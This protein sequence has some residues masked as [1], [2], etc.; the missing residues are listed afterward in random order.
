MSRYWRVR[1]R[2]PAKGQLECQGDRARPADRCARRG[3]LAP[4]SCLRS[5]AAAAWPRIVD[6]SDSGG[7]M[8]RMFILGRC[9][10]NGREQTEVGNGMQPRGVPNFPRS[11][12]SRFQSISS[13]L[14]HRRVRARR[15]VLSQEQPKTDGLPDHGGV[16]LEREPTWNSATRVQ[17]RK[18][19][20]AVR[21]TV[22]E[23]PERASR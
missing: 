14:R 8:S 6:W 3:P 5:Q 18:R 2:W 23:N 11:S 4:V 16:G 12:W 10:R 7:W 13:Q 22:P 21:L 19:P 20:S 15:A 1:A 17:A 9:C